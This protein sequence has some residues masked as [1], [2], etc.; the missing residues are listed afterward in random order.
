MATRVEIFFRSRWVERPEHVAELE[1]GR[2]PAGFRAA[3]VA[4]GSKP[5]GRLDVGALACDADDAVSVALFT[6]NTVV[7]APVKV[8]R[9]AQLDRL[10]GVVV[11]AGNA[12]VGTGARGVEVAEA[13]T[14]AAAA[15]LGVE[16]ARVGVAS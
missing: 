13:M 7:G 15:G 8:S 12:N 10:R 2:L 14:R 6:R 16:P 4:T 3:A 1:P 11:N 5:P 9:R